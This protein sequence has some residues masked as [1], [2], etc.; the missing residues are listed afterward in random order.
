MVLQRLEVGCGPVELV[1]AAVVGSS[2]RCSGQGGRRDCGGPHQARECAL[3]L[4]NAHVWP[5]THGSGI[6]GLA[7]SGGHTRLDIQPPIAATVWS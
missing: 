7:G 6:A 1:L 3:H 2:Y 5:G 4:R